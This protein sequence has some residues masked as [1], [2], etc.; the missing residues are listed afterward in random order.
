MRKSCQFAM[1]LVAALGLAGAAQ[2]AILT[3]ASIWVPLSHNGGSGPVPY[4]GP[5]PITGTGVGTS[6]GLGATATLASN[7]LIG[8]TRDGG[9][10]SAPPITK[11]YFTLSGHAAGSFL[12]GGGPGGGL[13]GP[14]TLSGFVKLKAYS[15]MVTLVAI[16]L[17]PVGQPG[18]FASVTGGGGTIIQAWGTGW[19]TGVQTMMFPA[20]TISGRTTTPTTVTATGADLR[21]A[22]GAGTLVLI[23]PLYFRSNLAGD[24]PIFARL[25][26]N[27]VPEPSTLLLV[28]LGMA[29]LALR[30]RKRQWPN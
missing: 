19:T 26:L 10:V 13:G 12:A 29:G 16:P 14:M 23:S 27:Y 24:I 28:G 7:S 11:V 18:G 4:Y 3:S 21:T 15:A 2:G 25:T 9:P 22:S 6:V 1:V 17:S 5:P 30:G 8:T 20:T